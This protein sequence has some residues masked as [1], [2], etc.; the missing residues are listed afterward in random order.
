MMEEASRDINS[1]VGRVVSRGLEGLMIRATLV[2]DDK[3]TFDVY[4]KGKGSPRL[5]SVTIERWKEP[6]GRDV[7]G[8]LRRG[9]RK[10]RRKVARA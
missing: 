8:E 1:F 3:R 2:T 7:I 6:T 5:W 4:E 9:L 10:D